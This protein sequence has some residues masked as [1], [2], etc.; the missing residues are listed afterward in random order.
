MSKF[1]TFPCRLTAHFAIIY[2]I[3]WLRWKGFYFRDTILFLNE[4]ERIKKSEHFFFLKETP[5]YDKINTCCQLQGSSTY[6]SL[7]IQWLK[8]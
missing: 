6:R 7:R 4:I 8:C 3:A 1:E 2:I 5:H